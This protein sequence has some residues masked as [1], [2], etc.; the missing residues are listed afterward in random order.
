ML[1]LTQMPAMDQALVPSGWTT[2]LAPVLSTTW[3][4]AP[5]TLIQLTADTL[6]MLEFS[7]TQHV[8]RLDTW[9]PTTYQKSSVT[10]SNQFISWLRTD[11]ESTFNMISYWHQLWILLHYLCTYCVKWVFQELMP[12]VMLC[13]CCAAFVSVWHLRTVM[14]NLFY[15]SRCLQQWRSQTEGRF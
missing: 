13:I 2:W 9:V 15:P 11:T 1:L 8:S 5:M 6:R 7:A 4:T 10:T 3:P 14:V 12:I